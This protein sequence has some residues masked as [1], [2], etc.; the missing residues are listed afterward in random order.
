[1]KGLLTLSIL[2]TLVTLFALGGYIAGGQETESGEEIKLVITTIG[3][4]SIERFDVDG[5]TALEILGSVHEVVTTSSYI[6]CLDN[7]CAGRDYH[8]MFYVNGKISS[9][10][11]A[12]YKAKRGDI[13]E[14]RLSRGG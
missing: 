9:E 11:A 10:S 4:T 5:F 3:K 7:I 13:L 6:T 2:A 12:I 8:W 1:M 14:F